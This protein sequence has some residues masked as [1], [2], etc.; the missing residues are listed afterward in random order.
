[1]R[2]IDI[3]AVG[4]S[5]GH[6]PEYFD[7]VRIPLFRTSVQARIVKLYHN[8]TPL[9]DEKPT[10]STFVDW[11]RQWNDN[12]GIWELDREMKSLQSQLEEVRGAIIAGERV[13][14]SI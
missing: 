14:I 11:H 2:L 1:M 13:T 10:L 6:S 7:Y 8:P 12:L 5:G 4:G 9:P 3:M